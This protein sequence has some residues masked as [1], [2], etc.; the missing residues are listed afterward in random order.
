MNAIGVAALL[1]AIGALPGAILVA[2][3][4]AGESLWGGSGPGYYEPDPI[5][6]L[7]KASLSGF[8]VVLA[9]TLLGSGL[10]G[11]W[12]LSIWLADQER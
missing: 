5:I 6:G 2:V 3:V 9:G 12:R 8:G 10:Y 11:L 7:F 4:V 1:G